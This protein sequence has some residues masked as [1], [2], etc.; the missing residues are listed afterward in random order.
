M[1]RWSLCIGGKTKYWAEGAAGVRHGAFGGTLTYNHPKLWSLVLFWAEQKDPTRT[2]KCL[3]KLQV[4]Q[5]KKEN[6]FD[7]LKHLSE[8][9]SLPC[10]KLLSW[11]GV[12]SFLGR[13]NFLDRFS[14]SCR[15]SEDQRD[16]RQCLK[17]APTTW[18]QMWQPLASCHVKVQPMAGG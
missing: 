6:L 10:L 7:T 1:Q 16:G 11:T 5:A 9:K 8:R 12:D 15:A 17:V 18:L 3:K 14:C 13:S 2:S 4:Q